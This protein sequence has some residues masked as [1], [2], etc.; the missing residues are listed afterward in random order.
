MQHSNRIKYPFL[1]FFIL[2]TH[3][4][5]RGIRFPG[6]WGYSHFLF[7]YQ[8][9]ITKRGL[10]GELIRQSNIPWLAEYG[11]YFLFSSL[12]FSINIILLCLLC[13][14]LIR[15]K[16]QPIIA[17]TFL[18]ASSLSLAFLSHT[19]GFFDHVGL[20]IALV[21]LRL[22]KFRSRYIWIL[23]SVPVGLLIHEALLIMFFPLLFMTLAI[24]MDDK[25]QKADLIKLIFLFVFILGITVFLGRQSLTHEDARAMY[26]SLQDQIEIPLRSDAFTVLSTGAMDS[27]TLML[28]VLTWPEKILLITYCLLVT[29]PVAFIYTYFSIVIL[30]IANK[31]WFLKLLAILAALSP[32][33]LHFLGWD[34]Q[35]WWTLAGTTSFLTFSLIYLENRERE[36]SLADHLNIF[37]AKCINFVFSVMTQIPL[38]KWLNDK[39]ENL[40]KASLE[41]KLITLIFV[42]VF[43]SLFMYIPFFEGYKIKYF[44]FVSHIQF[45]IDV[46]SGQ[47]SF[48][49]PPETKV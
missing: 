31:P 49:V 28:D 40:S 30:N 38:G 9:G 37:L 36:L 13:R 34:F 23:L 48:F 11:S 15:G 21:A 19:I 33:T 8:F 45:I 3:S 25:P 26:Q 20:L 17:I 14:D 47:E 27:F 43:A 7:N 39:L 35:R 22:Q 44:P 10:I 29:A 42:I 2:L 16:N 1:I 6:I 12:I 32:L 18:F 24:K 41:R 5:L 4:I 46:I